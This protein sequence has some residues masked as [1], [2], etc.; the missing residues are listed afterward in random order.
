M[1]SYTLL[2]LAGIIVF[3]F[4]LSQSALAAM[5]QEATVMLVLK[6]LE[7]TLPDEGDRNET[8]G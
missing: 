4:A 8:A 1:K 3:E 6:R 2:I 7:V 5:S